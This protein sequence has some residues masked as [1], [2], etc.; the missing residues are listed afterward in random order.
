MFLDVS[1][2]LLLAVTIGWLTNTNHKLWL[3]IF[4]ATASLAPDVDLIVYLLK[5]KGK[6]DQFAHE[7]RDLLHK[8][9]PFSAG[10]AFL[11]CW[12]DLAYKVPLSLW[13]L[14]WL[15]ATAGHF[16]HDT[17]EGGWGIQWLWPLETK[18]YLW[19]KHR[20]R[21]VIYNRDEQRE[22]AAQYGDPN[23]LKNSFRWQWQTV[24]KIIFFVAMLTISVFWY[25]V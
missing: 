7:H 18:Y 12:L 17:F 19:G 21:A 11:M 13:A 6:L 24:T 4:G 23:W 5:H 8:P 9:L 20:P 14:V 2:G 1:I 22:I 15:S 10:V 3:L 25:M 16:V